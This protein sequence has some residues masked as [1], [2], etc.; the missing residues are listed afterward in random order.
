M[1][2]GELVSLRPI[3]ASDLPAMRGWFDDPDTMKYWGFP[4]PFISERQF[5]DDLSTRFSRFESEG[6]FMILD[7]NGDPIGRIDY[8]TL[9]IRNRSCELGILIGE[10]HARNKR[11]GSDAIVA[12]LHHLFRD[13]NLHRVWLTVLA[14]NE[15]AIRAYRHVGFR[16][17]GVLR[18]H[19]YVDGEYVDELQMSMLRHEFDSLFP[20]S[21]PL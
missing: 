10:E 21:R 13:R 8:D 20:Q 16:E 7:P 19:R 9:D 5:E 2:Q 1:I 11:Y 12:L 4:R 3:S 14:W 18:D 15:R 6:Y 17:E